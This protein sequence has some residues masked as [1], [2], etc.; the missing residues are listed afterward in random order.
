MDDRPY[1]LQRVNFADGERLWNILPEKT[2]LP[3]CECFVAG[4]FEPGPHT[5]QK[6]LSIYGLQSGREHIAQGG[7]EHAVEV[8]QERSRGC[9]LRDCA[10]PRPCSTHEHVYL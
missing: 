7:F 3:T 1:L 10:L 9:D 8:H 4:D 2:S 5:P 6:R